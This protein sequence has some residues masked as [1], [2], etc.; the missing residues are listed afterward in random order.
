MC[1]TPPP[2]G[3]QAAAHAHSPF[4]PLLPGVPFPVTSQAPRRPAR[5]GPHTNA[6]FSTLPPKSQN[7]VLRT[8]TWTKLQAPHQDFRATSR[9]FTHVCPLP[10]LSPPDSL[11]SG[12]LASVFLPS[13]FLLPSPRPSRRLHSC[14]SLTSPWPLKSL[15]LAREASGLTLFPLRSEV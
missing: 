3:P 4:L 6:L 2:G 8:S 9:L 14:L 10:S 11:Y 15:P 1:T 12:A 7:K 13:L 5:T